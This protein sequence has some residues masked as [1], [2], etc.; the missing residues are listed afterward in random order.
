MVKK[1]IFETVGELFCGPGG[2]ALG[3]SLAGFENHKAQ[4][5]IRHLWATDKDEDSCN[6]YS[7]NIR[8]FENKEFGINQFIFIMF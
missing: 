5:R 3:S 4:V 7:K 8:H 2:G 6:T 1:Q